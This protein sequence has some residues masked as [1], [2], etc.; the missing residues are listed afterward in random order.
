MPEKEHRVDDGECIASIAESYG[1]FGG[2][3]WDHR[4]N[5][6][7][8]NM[9]ENPGTLMKGDVVRIPER[10]EKELE[11]APEQRHRF[12]R[13]GVPDRLKMRLIKNGRARAN[14]SYRLDIDGVLHEG[15]TDADGYL[16]H[17]IPPNARHA[18]LLIDPDERHEIRL[19]SLPPKG[20]P[21]GLEARLRNLGFIATKDAVDDDQVRMALARFQSAN[22]LELS[23]DADDATWE[24][25][26]EVHEC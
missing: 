10:Q 24:R 18:E 9:R 15:K 17:P 21:E 13:K 12:R 6:E 23:D 4:G 7:L 16:D 1:F 3:L 26:V 14:L 5:A 19:G 22:G 20:S 11:K 8:R 25:L 2:T